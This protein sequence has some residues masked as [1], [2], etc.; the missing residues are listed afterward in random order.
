MSSESLVLLLSKCHLS[1]SVLLFWVCNVKHNTWPIL[2]FNFV[3]ICS[4]RSIFLSLDFIACLSL[5]SS[6]FCILITQLMLIGM[7]VSIGLTLDPSWKCFLDIGLW[8]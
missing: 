7:F 1:Y 4:T 5:T 6:L 8:L 3:F 2:S